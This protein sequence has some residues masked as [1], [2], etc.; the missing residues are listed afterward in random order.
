MTEAEWFACTDPQT[1]LEFLRG[2]ASGRKLRLFA[3]ACFR[4]YR[5]MLVPDTLDALAVAEKFADGLATAE[6]RKQARQKAFRAGW[7]RDLSLRH[8]RGPAKACVT[9]ALA[10]RP[11]EAAIRAAHRGRQIGILSKRDWKADALEMTERGPRIVDWS[12][13]KQEQLLFQVNILLDIF[14]NIFHPVNFEP[15]CGTSDV[16][17]QARVIYEEHAFER[18]PILGDALVDAGC[19]NEE[20]LAH[21]RNGRLHFRGCWVVDS[22]LGKS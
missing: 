19:E 2:R 10:R 11:Y 20:L 12:S 17:D 18:L 14:G 22:I 3:L 5:Y 6:E 8:R 21:C 7:N 13:G 9:D 1:M 15:R 4:Q 16:L